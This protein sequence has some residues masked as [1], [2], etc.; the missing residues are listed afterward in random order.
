MQNT[1]NVG[2]V[3]TLG[4]YSREGTITIGA[5]SPP[6]GD[7]SEPVTVK[8]IACSQSIRGLDATL[9]QK[10]HFPSM[11]WLTSYHCMIQVNIWTETYY[12]NWS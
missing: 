4:S 3:E 2:R 9:A 5:V 7:T 10:R 12:A 11:N 6:G 8:Y 1:T